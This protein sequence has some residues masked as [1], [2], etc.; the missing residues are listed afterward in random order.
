MGVEKIFNSSVEFSSQPRADNVDEASA[1]MKRLSETQA[2]KL[3][4]KGLALLKKAGLKETDSLIAPIKVYVRPAREG[5]KDDDTRDRQVLGEQS[6]GKRQSASNMLDVSLYVSLYPKIF[7]YL[8]A[9]GGSSHLNV[10]FR[11][12]VR[13]QLPGS[14]F[15]VFKLIMNTDIAKHGIRLVGKELVLIKPPSSVAPPS[16]KKQCVCQK[17]IHF[18]SKLEW[19]THVLD[20]FCESHEL[21]E[22]EL[23]RLSSST[24]RWFYCLVCNRPFQDLV[25][26]IKHCGNMEDTEHKDFGSVVL[27][28]SLDPSDVVYQKLLFQA[29]NDGDTDYQIGRAHV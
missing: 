26:I 29:M 28:T 7:E 10:V 20:N 14:S 5:L 9:H 16:Q 3:Y 2:S 12:I 24:G 27:S 15:T 1:R 23:M 25:R 21:Y 4:G 22:L 11:D 19:A 17:N 8:T 6:V 18:K 13:P